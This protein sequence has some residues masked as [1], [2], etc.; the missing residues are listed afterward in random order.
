[1]NGRCLKLSANIAALAIFTFAVWRVGSMIT[2]E[3]IVASCNSPSRVA[4]E[5]NDAV[6]LVRENVG[7]A[8]SLVFHV[9]D[10]S[11]LDGLDRQFVS[12][13][14]FDRGHDG[15]GPHRNTETRRFAES[16]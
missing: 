10:L 14:A 9:D 7:P 13:I 16:F 3:K 2:P 8:E 11:R 15:V 6:R 1:M 12:A 4:D 5:L